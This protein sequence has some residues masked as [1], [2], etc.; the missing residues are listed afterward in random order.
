MLAALVLTEF[1]R[2]KGITNDR[3]WAADVPKLKHYSQV[4][5]RV[6]FV[7]PQSF[8]LTGFQ[9]RPKM[10]ISRQHQ[11]KSHVKDA[12]ITKYRAVSIV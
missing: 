2:P 5:L 6:C 12:L 3:I 1:C 10:E 8:W 11:S 9:V 4:R 7:A